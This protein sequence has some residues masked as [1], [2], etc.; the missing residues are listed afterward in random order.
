MVILHRF[1]VFLL[2]YA[3]YRFQSSII[4]AIYIFTVFLVKR[5]PFLV[6]LV[7]VT[8]AIINSSI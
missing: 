3:T 1:S 7:P 2:P 4:V 8:V 6:L 5:V